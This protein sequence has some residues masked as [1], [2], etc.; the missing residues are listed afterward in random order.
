MVHFDDD[1]PW[2]IRRSSGK[3]TI[4]APV[5]CEWKFSLCFGLVQDST[6]LEDLLLQ[7]GDKTSLSDYT[8]SWLEITT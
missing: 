8:V 1:E 3:K 6:V 4:V 5:R 7:S 2:T